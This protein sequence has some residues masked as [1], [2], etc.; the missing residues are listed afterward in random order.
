[1]YPDQNHEITRPSFLKDRY[2]RTADWFGK[3]LQP[4]P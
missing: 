2:Q 1:V 3:Y 4:A